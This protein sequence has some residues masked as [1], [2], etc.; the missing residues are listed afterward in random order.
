MCALTARARPLDSILN[1]RRL[2]C[3]PVC[4]HRTPGRQLSE[5]PTAVSVLVP[6]IRSTKKQ[7]NEKKKKKRF[8]KGVEEILRHGKIPQ[9]SPAQ[10]SPIEKQK[11]DVVSHSA[12]LSSSPGIPLGPQSSPVLSEP[13]EGVS[14]ELCTG[15]QAE[16]NMQRGLCQAED[17]WKGRMPQDCL[18]PLTHGRRG[19]SRTPQQPAPFVRDPS[20][21]GRSILGSPEDQLGR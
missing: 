4:Q 20:H 15:S 6:L 17:R 1:D 18:P 12:L 8:L 16:R 14:V 10:P 21:S 13:L 9:P 3:Q 2:L 5:H 19:R 11:L 7:Q